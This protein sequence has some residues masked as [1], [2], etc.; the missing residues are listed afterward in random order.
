MTIKT[1]NNKITKKKNTKTKQKH[2]EN[3]R[4]FYTGQFLLGMKPDLE[5]G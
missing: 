5:C 2:T 1:N 3:M 4:T